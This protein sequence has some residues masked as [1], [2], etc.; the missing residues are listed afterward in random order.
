MSGNKDDLIADALATFEGDERKLMKE[1]L[2][3]LLGEQ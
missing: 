3:L 1:A 2:Y